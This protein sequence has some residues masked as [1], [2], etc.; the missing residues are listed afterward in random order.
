MQILQ[1]IRHAT[2]A[3]HEALENGYDMLKRLAC[4][5]GRQRVM[6]GLYCV[7][8]P[9]ERAL[10][11]FLDDLPGLRFAARHKSQRPA[12][13]LLE[14]GLTPAEFA[15]LPLE[16]IPAFGGTARALG[17]AYV[18]EGATLG[19]AVIRKRLAASG[20]SL[21]GFSFY[22]C[23]GSTLGQQWREFCALLEESCSGRADEA[24]EGACDGFRA[25]R[26]SLR[27]SLGAPGALEPVQ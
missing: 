18:L 22:D 23:Y 11:P 3:E 24:V 16:P 13:D 14:L 27:R 20:D 2:R 17:F 7:Y 1:Q 15:S 4:L 8:A 10:S 5:P 26:N 12:E 25:V 6:V 19:G 21:A 9:A